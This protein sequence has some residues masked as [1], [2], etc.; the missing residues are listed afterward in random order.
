MSRDEA[1]Q[2]S[3][4]PAAVQMSRDEAV[5]M[6]TLSASVQMSRDASLLHAIEEVLAAKVHDLEEKHQ[7]LQAAHRQLRLD[8]ESLEAVIE[9]CN[10]AITIARRDVHRLEAQLRKYQRR[11]QLTRK[12]RQQLQILKQTAAWKVA[13]ISPLFKDT[14]PTNFNKYRMLAVSSVLY[15]LYANVLQ[16]VLTAWCMT[17]KVLPAEQF[18]F[19]PGRS[20]MQPMFILRH[21]VHAQKAI[22]DAKHRRLFTAFIDFKQAYDHIPRQ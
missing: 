6:S 13:R 22:V 5:Q 12:Q 20:T 4:V 7:H 18:G 17:H 16:H 8:N 1:V 19:I 2:M 21:L 15:R 3:S 11:P 14:D 10:L 9:E